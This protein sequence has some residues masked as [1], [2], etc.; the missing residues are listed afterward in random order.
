MPLRRTTRARRKRSIVWKR[1]RDLSTVE[2]RSLGFLS[3]LFTA[4]GLPTPRLRYQVR[5]ERDAL[6]SM[7][8]PA[9]DDCVLRAM[10]D[11]SVIGGAM[12]LNARRDGDTV[13]FAYPSVIL[14]ATKP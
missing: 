2:F 12:G 10:I 5:V 7:S 8:F 13:R 14:V 11:Q 3:G 6:I 1:H 9:A 4:A